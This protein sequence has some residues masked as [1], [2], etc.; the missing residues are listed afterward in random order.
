MKTISLFSLFVFIPMSYGGFCDFKILEKLSE[1]LEITLELHSLDPQRVERL[2]EVLNKTI[3]ENI[4]ALQIEGQTFTKIVG[5]DLLIVQKANEES[6]D[7]KNR[8]DGKIIIVK[9][10]PEEYLAKELIKK[11]KKKD[12]KKETPTP[13][14]TPLAKN[15]PPIPPKTPTPPAPEV[16]GGIRAQ[17]RKEAHEKLKEILEV[18]KERGIVSPTEKVYVNSTTIENFYNGMK[19]NIEKIMS[20]LGLTRVGIAEY[21]LNLEGN[22]NPSREEIESKYNQVRRIFRTNSHF[23]GEVT[24]A[25]FAAIKKYAETYQKPALL[26]EAE[27]KQPTIEPQENDTPLTAEAIQEETDNQQAFITTTAN[28]LGINSTQLLEQY[29]KGTQQSLHT[30]KILEAI[31]QKMNINEEAFGALLGYYPTKVEAINMPD[32]RSR[33]ASKA[34]MYRGRLSRAIK[35]LEHIQ[36]GLENAVDYSS[37]TYAS[38][39]EA[40]NH[41]L[42]PLIDIMLQYPMPGTTS[43]T[44]TQL[45][46][47]KKETS[48]EALLAKTEFFR[49]YIQSTNAKGSLVEKMVFAFTGDT[50]LSILLRDISLPNRVFVLGSEPGSVEFEK[51]VALYTELI[52]SVRVQKLTNINDSELSSAVTELL[53]ECKTYL[54]VDDSAKTQSLGELLENIIAERKLSQKPELDLSQISPER[55]KSILGDK[56]WPTISEIDILKEAITGNRNNTSKNAPTRNISLIFFSR[57]E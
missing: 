48:R 53:Q 25:V 4:S 12:T 19:R 57:E 51:L 41:K 6:I 3:L 30:G 50:K 13:D 29:S 14:K 26:T 52:T 31:R 34:W 8:G 39:M 28:I 7:I 36:N 18:M 55:L 40:R 37:M 9:I 21:M 5:N 23:T 27:L 44:I 46:K 43:E 24:D 17:L 16:A 11:E 38:I 33:L 42:N 35:E 22:K 56:T 32:I 20:H 49:L 2:T 47:L 1:N 54:S 10:K 45:T 15:I